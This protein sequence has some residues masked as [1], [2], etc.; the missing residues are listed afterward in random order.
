MNK[1]FLVRTS[2]SDGLF[3]HG[4]FVPKETKSALLFIHG[5]EGNFYENYFVQLLAEE[6]ANQGLTFL[7]ANTRGNGKDTNFDT[8]DGSGKRIGSYYEV[9]EESYIDIDAWVEFLIKEGYDEIVLSGH[10]LGTYKVVRYLFEGRHKDKIRK[11]LLLS[12]FDG[13]GELNIQMPQWQDRLREAEEEI[14]KGK[15]E[16]IP[17][18]WGYPLGQSY[19]N[20][21]SW[22]KQDDFGRMFEFCNKDYNFPVLNKIAIPT[23]IIVGSKDEFFH[24]SNPEHPEE[25]MDILLKN[26][27]NSESK[28]INDAVHS[29]APHEEILVN[30]V[31]EFV[32]K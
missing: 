24:L 10:S 4:F 17:T 12:P 5:F 20:F 22:Y 16:T 2:T 1:P 26:I 15:G 30:E 19:Q 32:K 31:I 21:A 7:T 13:I 11:L 25:A 3:L 9:L 29:F 18:A 14:R 23:K 6:C 8:V 27:P 28:I